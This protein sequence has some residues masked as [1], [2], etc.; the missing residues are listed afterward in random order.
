MGAHA[1]YMQ[2]GK[3]VKFVNTSGS[4]IV[5]REAKYFNIP[6]FIIAE[7]KK[8][9]D[10]TESEEEKVGYTEEKLITKSLEDEGIE[11]LEVAYDLCDSN[12]NVSFVCEEGIIK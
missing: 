4:D 6:V 5:L 10:W 11:T 1:V 9:K 12:E 7:K 8:C 2:D 3:M